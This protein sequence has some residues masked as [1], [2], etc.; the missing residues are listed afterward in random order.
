MSD[1]L[2]F[3]GAEV[4][5]LAAKLDG[6]DG[7]TD[8]E[9]RLLTGVFFIA[10]QSVGDGNADVSGF[11]PTAVENVSLNFANTA[12]PSYLQG[13]NQDSPGWGIKGFS[14]GMHASG[15]G[16]GAGKVAGGQLTGGI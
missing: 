5:A 1:D 16:G 8:R 10:G 11:M 9:R 6:I 13:Q 4:E 12:L 14:W 15:G 3:T 2:I 7:L